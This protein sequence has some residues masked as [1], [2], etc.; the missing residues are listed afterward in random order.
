MHEDSSL[1]L[2]LKHAVWAFHTRGVFLNKHR[3][4]SGVRN[5]HPVNVEALDSSE[6][7][8]ADARVSGSS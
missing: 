7:A 1:M 2:E 3:G 6:A 5:W 8:G 4:A